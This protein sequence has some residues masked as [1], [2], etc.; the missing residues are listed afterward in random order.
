MLSVRKAKLVRQDV[1][2]AAKFEPV[3]DIHN[4]HRDGTIHVLLFQ[5][6][7][8][9]IPLYT[10]NTIMFSHFKLMFI[11]LQFWGHCACEA[12]ISS[13]VLMQHMWWNIFWQWLKRMSCILLFKFPIFAFPC[14]ND[15][16]SK[17]KSSCLRID[18]PHAPKGRPV[19]LQ[20]VDK[21][22]WFCELR[23]PKTFFNTPYSHIFPKILLL[24]T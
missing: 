18:A 11:K 12:V 6:E 14:R 19:I 22:M 20:L 13:Q 3:E 4:H 17:H 23:I 5:N 7:F 24:L 16:Y 1:S 8:L 2:F 21:E 15:F 9:L 10:F